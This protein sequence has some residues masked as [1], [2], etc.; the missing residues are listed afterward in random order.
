MLLKFNRYISENNL[1]SPGGRV[2][3]AISGGIDSMVMLH[4]FISAGV[5]AG[6]AH[7]NFTLRGKES[8]L[9]EK[10]VADFAARNDIPFFSARF[11]TARYAKEHSI[12]V[13]MAARELRY[14]WFEKIRS[15]NGYD[16]VAVAHNLNDNA[17]TLLLNLIRGTG[18][19]GLAGMKIISG[20]I[21]RPMLFAT[22]EEIVKYGS[23]NDIQYR[24]DRS[25][26]D[27]KYVRNKIRHKIIPL[28]KE[29]NPSVDITLNETALRIGGINELLT[30]YLD[31]LREKLTDKRDGLEAVKINN[32]LPFI[33]NKA[34]LFEIF[35][36]YGINSG[37]LEDLINIMQG[38]S[39]GEVFSG[40][41]RFIRNRDEIL[42]YAGRE[43]SFISRDISDFD[44]LTAI[45]GIESVTIRK[46][47]KRFRMPENHNTVCL[48]ADLVS[49]PLTIRN[50]QPGD[51]FFPLGM[52]KKKKL[53]DFFT[54]RKYSTADKE[55]ALIMISQE[56]IVCIIGERIDNRYRITPSSRRALIIKSGKESHKNI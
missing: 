3:L 31:D 13:Q 14:A 41:H 52:N 5:N 9:D 33:T 55:N 34:I 19:S 26:S 38:G 45:R 18:I 2:L 46:I 40:S 15:E 11:P 6:I 8:D 10:L 29:I 43:K 49:L 51:S 32:L 27:T 47:T 28:L 37:T 48:D 7:C 30:N 53:S 42:I 24:E 4:L 35:R 23:K 20:R 39:G 21:I 1:V 44:G 16:S 12:S 50:W 56:Q 22:R 25:N 36:P 54:D 17:E